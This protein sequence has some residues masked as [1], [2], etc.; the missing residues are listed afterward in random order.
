MAYGRKCEG[1]LRFEGEELR[2]DD[3]LAMTD[4]EKAAPEDV[5]RRLRARGPQAETKQAAL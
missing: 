1:K 5:W 3:T 4:A 2:E